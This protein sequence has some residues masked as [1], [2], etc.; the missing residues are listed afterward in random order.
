MRPGLVIGEVWAARKAQGLSGAR[1]K[2]VALQESGRPGE[3]LS[4]KVVVAQDTLDA[5]TGQRVLVAF[6]SGARNVITPGP[7]NRHVLCDAAIA[8]LIDGE[9]GDG[10]D[11]RAAF[12]QGGD[13]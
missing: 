8:L 3:G 1:L 5:R 7:H 11:Q 9:G 6:G 13:G 12:A 4:G 2:L 10:G